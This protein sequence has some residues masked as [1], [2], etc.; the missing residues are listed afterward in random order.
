MAN[1]FNQ[2]NYRKVKQVF[3]LEDSE[4]SVQLDEAS[5]FAQPQFYTTSQESVR[6]AREAARYE[7]L[8]QPCDIYIHS[9]SAGTMQER[10]NDTFKQSCKTNFMQL[11]PKELSPGRH[12]SPLATNLRTSNPQLDMGGSPPMHQL[13]LPR[14]EPV[15]N[16]SSPD[17]HSPQHSSDVGL[18]L[19]VHQ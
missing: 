8:K 1:G 11:P 3:R 13:N 6:S 19:R 2:E 14:H 17:L 7:E 15:I 18:S 4:H 9:P 5:D 16:H 10:V 12:H